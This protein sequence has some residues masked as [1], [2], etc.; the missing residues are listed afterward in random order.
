MANRYLHPLAGSLSRG[1]VIV[2]GRFRPNGTSAV[3]NTLNKGKGFT[4][5]RTAA[6]D[7]TITLADPFTELNAGFVQIH[8]AAD[9]DLV[10]SLGAELVATAGTQTVKLTV[11]T[12]TTPTDMASDAD[13]WISFM[14]LLK[15]TSVAG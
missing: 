9:T 6:G 3:D 12:A 11:L 13:S 8:A 1:L 7:F 15:N 10:A 14:L 2:S 4:V 5:A